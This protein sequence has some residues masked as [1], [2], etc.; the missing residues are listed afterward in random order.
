MR[1]SR[2][3]EIGAAR[4]TSGT[5]LLEIEGLRTHFKTSRGNA[6]VINGVDLRIDA[7][8]V[9]G[10]VGES[11]SG[12]SVTAR[13]ILGILPKRS[14]ALREGSIR[15]RGQELLEMPEKQLRSEIRGRQIAMV[16][17]DPMTALNPVMRL[18]QQLSMPIRL[19]QGLSKRDALAKA[20][21]L[22]HQVGIPDPQGRL[23]SF[24][25]ELS[26]GQRQRVMIAIALACDPQLLIADEPTTALD[27][28]VQAQILDLF[29][30]LREDRGLA[31]LL[32]SHDLGLIAERCDDVSVMYAGEVVE[33]GGAG[34]VFERP[35]HP[36]TSLLEGARPRLENPPPTPLNTS[37][38]RPPNLLDRPPGCAF[39]DRCPRAI[40][41]CAT[42]HPELVPDGHTVRACHNPV[43]QPA[44]VGADGQ[45]A[46]TAEGMH[47]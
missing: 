42:V 25:H 29:E 32:V 37:A 30:Q 44:G 19:H 7:G 40:D 10:L 31:I 23:R 46:Q 47:A 45:H 17:Q 4:A 39:R 36:Y 27:V 5:P 41:I 8:Q 12:K 20:A 28:T 18:G 21:D 15:Y 3:S 14:I 9:H 1:A 2:K 34:A 22:L 43:P 35:R 33:R 6:Q 26:G 13:S 11:G 38:G 24:P 16:F